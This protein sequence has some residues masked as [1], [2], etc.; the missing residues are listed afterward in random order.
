MS[1]LLKSKILLGVMIF[2]VMFVGFAVVKTASAETCDLGT[3]TLKQGMSGTAVTCLQ[4][5]LAVTPMTGYFGSITKAKVIAF[6]SAN[7]LVADGVVGNLTKAALGMVTTTTTTTTAGCTA[8]AL[9]SST[10]GAPCATVTSST[11]T[12]G[13]GALDD[14]KE[15]TSGM[16]D[17][18]GEGKTVNVLG[19][20]VAADNGS[21]L[22][23]TGLKLAFTHTSD[24]SE[25]LNHYFSE[26]MVYNGST[27]VGSADV[28][29]FTT[30]NPTS[31]TILLSNVVV[32]AGEKV[33]LTVKLV[34]NDV[35]RSSSTA[36]QDDLSAHWN[37]EAT[38]VRFVDASGAIM[39]DSDTGSLGSID[40]DVTFESATT[41]DGLRLSSSSSNPDA[42]TI[43][44]D[45]NDTSDDNLVL[46]F[47][48][49]G[50]TD[51]SDLSVTT[52]P[53]VL[54]L[55]DPSGGDG[56]VLPS[57]VIND[58]YLK[59]GS[60]VYDNFDI[61]DAG[62]AMNNS[63]D[64]TEYTFDI[65]EGDLTVSAD[66]YTEVKVYVSYGKQDSKYDSGTTVSAAVTASEI[67]VVNDN[68]DAVDVEGSSSATG[69]DQT[70][71]LNGATIT[72]V[73]S[74]STKIDDAGTIR[75]FTLVF[76]VSAIG[77]NFEVTKAITGFSDT[78]DGSSTGDVIFTVP[79]PGAI[80]I[81]ASA[82]LTSTASL[83]GGTYTVFDGQTKRFTLV[84]TLSDASATGQFQV[85]LDSV[86]GS[87]ATDVETDSATIVI[88]A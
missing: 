50:D 82:S 47:R 15:F 29:D 41:S 85:V 63:S 31:K 9:F 54:T 19:V 56:S 51:S 74:S 12:G 72:Y 23:I 34:A 77:D 7:Q 55:T 86:T 38:A 3:V 40:V 79:T 43:K 75:D 53:V 65:D 10:T 88:G 20:E 32:K 81:D 71:Q 16:D 62:A 57:D 76:D 2:A 21:D 45:E 37:V 14:V 18:I 1:K 60:T 33:R 35:I 64:T 52:I 87:P 83:S 39:T 25:R 5:K 66:E 70:L 22:A 58:V 28:A 42:T 26:V 24:G 78:N 27:K 67:V 84:V 46:A 44:V 49:K 13:I 30:D 6:Q 36:S 61:T 68:G 8:G 59:V 11:L 17:V 73:S 80:T 4:T 69:E 48:L